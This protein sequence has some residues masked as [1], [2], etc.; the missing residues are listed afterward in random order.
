MTTYIFNNVESIHSMSFA[1][2]GGSQYRCRIPKR[3]VRGMFTAG[4]FVD[5]EQFRIFLR[6]IAGTPAIVGKYIVDPS[7]ILGD[8]VTHWSVVIDITFAVPQI[9][10]IY[11]ILNYDFMYFES[12]AIGAGIEASTLGQLANAH[13]AVDGLDRKSTRLNSSHSSVSRMPSSA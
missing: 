9:P 10:V 6:E 12:G 1:S 5:K 3:D 13:D 11:D 8:N 2:L 7:N 4:I